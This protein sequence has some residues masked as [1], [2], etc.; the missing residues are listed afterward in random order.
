EAKTLAAIEVFAG[1]PTDPSPFAQGAAIEQVRMKRLGKPPTWEE[2]QTDLRKTLELEESAGPKQIDT[3]GRNR[4]IQLLKDAEDSFD[5]YMEKQLAAITDDARRQAARVRMETSAQQ[6]RDALGNVWIG[7]PV[8]LS[9][10]IGEAAAHTRE[11]YFGIVTKIERKGRAKNPLAAGAWRIGVTVA[12]A[13]RDIRFAASKT[14][15]R[16]QEHIA[17]VEVRIPQQRALHL[18]LGVGTMEEAY[19]KAISTSHETRYIATGNLLAAYGKVDRGQIINYTDDRGTL[20]Q[21][22]LLPRSFDLQEALASKEAELQTPKAAADFF[23]T[24]GATEAAFLSTADG[25]LVMTK[26]GPRHFRLSVAISKRNGARF[27]LNPDILAI[28]RDFV[29]A[30]GRMRADVEI[31]TQPGF[32]A[33]LGAI[34][35]AGG[36]LQATTPEHIRVARKIQG[37][38]E[39]PEPPKSFQEGGG[40]PP[41][42]GGFLSLGGSAT[43]R[44]E[45][46]ER[47]AAQIED[48][49]PGITI[50]GKPKDLGWLAA[51]GTISNQARHTGNRTIIAA[52]DNL[53]ETGM[54]MRAETERQL[55]EDRHVF[56]Q[57]PRE[58]RKAKGARFFELMDQTLTPDEVDESTTIP[59][60]VKPVLKHFKLR[61]EAQR[62]AIRARLWDARAAMYKQHDVA[63]L[64]A[65]AQEKGL[66]IEVEQHGQTNRL[67]DTELDELTTKERVAEDLAD[68]DFPADWGIQ[69]GHIQHVFYGGLR[70]VSVDSEGKEHFLGRAETE[71]EAYSKLSVY[72]AEHEGEDIA[73]LIAKPAVFLR[74]D[75]VRV[76][77]SRLLYLEKQLEEHATRQ[78]VELDARG[79]M[80]GV[81]GA[82]ESK[83][84]WWGPLQQRKGAE[85]YSTDFWRV[86]STQTAGFYRWTHLT[87]MNRAVAPMIET[88][89][90]QGLPRWANH[91]EDWKEYL[92][93][94]RRGLAAEALDDFLKKLPVVR[95]YVR[96]LAL[97]RMLGM[98]KTVQFFRHLQTA[99]FYVLNSLQ[100]LQTLWPVVKGEGMIAALKL[101]Y[102][103]EG[104]EIL[105]RHKVTIAGAKFTES[106]QRPRQWM[107]WL[108][109]GASEARNQALS[110]LALYDHARNKLGMSDKAAASYGRL[111]GQVFTQFAYSPADQPKW[112]RGPILGVMFQYKR[113]TVKQLEMLSTL[114]RSGDYGGVARFVAAQTMIGGLRALFFV[115]RWGLRLGLPAM[116]VGLGKWLK[117]KY[118]EA[119]ADA[120]VYGL[121]GLLGVDMS[122][123]LTPIDVPYGAT[124]AEKIGNVVLGPTGQDIARLW[125]DL[126]ESK[127]AQPREPSE[128][129]GRFLLERSPSLSQFYYLYKALDRDTSQYDSKGRRLYELELTDLWRKAGSF[130]T[131]HESEQRLV[132]DALIELKQEYDRT[133][134]G[135]AEKLMAKDAEGARAAADNWNARWP[136]AR[137]TT[138]DA[139]R[140][141]QARQESAETAASGRM[142][143]KLPKKLRRLAPDQEEDLKTMRGIQTAYVRAV[144][145]LAY[146][147]ETATE[148]KTLRDIHPAL[149]KIDQA[150]TEKGFKAP[151]VRN[152]AIASVRSSYSGLFYRAVRLEDDEAVA[153]YAR[154]RAALGVRTQ[155]TLLEDWI[156]DEIQRGQDREETRR[157]ARRAADVVRRALRG[158]D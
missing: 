115:S 40:N 16:G 78:G 27:Y 140:R 95:H 59:E 119:T 57:L 48:R 89:R 33:L 84:K 99:R 133:L 150:A 26:T 2:V 42:S 149:R 67:R 101:L 86:W 24:F 19:E 113:F 131:V 9:I 128:R 136:E 147:A 100:P 87:D 4:Q 58:Y 138:A 112:M 53:V 25:S 108:P 79:A 47:R 15:P 109:A 5:A 145:E 51:Q 38:P 132:M 63:A 120:V 152:D 98:V 90:K 114:A 17:A 83:W 142:V 124:A 126:S 71:A 92:W 49:R 146:A 153:Q 54:L 141:M 73:R 123:S 102:S 6:A 148:R 70:L 3:A 61:D 139:V 85:G 144:G 52:A 72:R 137:I 43:N 55:T 122:G 74:G 36:E 81:V 68:I 151:A 117:D 129:A 69:W 93:G 130:R 104:Q 18:F 103:A 76:N 75:V 94:R 37:L 46:A 155:I 10:Q 29:S 31:K 105:H 107:R 134:D 28:T 12:D 88:I 23:D 44:Q 1:D 111:R 127:M 97:E 116:L 121:P 157:L 41:M 45:A 35:K 14:V 66:S 64:A 11:L 154:A 39:K 22:I 62:K 20:R 50:Y 77:R 106:G 8:E 13:A 32:M 158:K 143:Q 65:L 118:G 56:R 91:L 7:R 125:G 110:F 21:G 60:A 135:V 80:R 96:P 34:Y 30:G 82:K 156:K